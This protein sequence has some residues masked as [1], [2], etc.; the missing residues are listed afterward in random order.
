MSEMQNR[1]RFARLTAV[2]GGSLLATPLISDTSAIVVVESG[3]HSGLGCCVN[4]VEIL[5]FGLL[6]TENGVK[7]V[8]ASD[9]NYGG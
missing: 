2:R 9:A 4:S 7:G 6:T 5:R 1:S 8:M 3:A